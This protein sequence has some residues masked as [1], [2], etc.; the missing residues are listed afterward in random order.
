V[1]GGFAPPTPSIQ[2]LLESLVIPNEV[3][4]LLQFTGHYCLAINNNRL[5]K[6]FYKKLELGFICIM[7]L[8]NLKLENYE[9]N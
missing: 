4:N 3:R 7:I 5:T 8:L 2:Q 9:S 1:G 6:K